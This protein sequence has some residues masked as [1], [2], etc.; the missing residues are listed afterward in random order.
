M[1][2]RFDDIINASDVKRAPAPVPSLQVTK[3]KPPANATKKRPKTKDI[4]QNLAEVLSDEAIRDAINK[5]LASGQMVFDSRIARMSYT[6]NE[7]SM[8]EKI[9]AIKFLGRNQHV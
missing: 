8:E 5:K 4:Y 2:D 7:M 1:S 9:H 6:R 3:R